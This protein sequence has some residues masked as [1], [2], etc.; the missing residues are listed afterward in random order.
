[1]KKINKNINKTS[2]KKKEKSTWKY[3]QGATKYFPSGCDGAADWLMVASSDD[4]IKKGLVSGCCCW[5]FATVCCFNVLL[6]LFSLPIISVSSSIVGN[7]SYLPLRPFCRL[8]SLLLK[9][10][11][12][13]KKK[14]QYHLC[15]I[16]QI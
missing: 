5:Y 13:E 11:N 16:S 8:L 2:T 9:K 3:H 12:T 7:G 15:H 4:V 1:M 14:I 10:C 6:S